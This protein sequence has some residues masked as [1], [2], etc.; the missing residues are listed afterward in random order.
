MPKIAKDLIKK[1]FKEDDDEF[2][3]IDLGEA[4]LKGLFVCG[5]QIKSFLFEKNTGH[6]AKIISEW[7]KQESIS[8]REIKVAVKG[9]QT[10]I[11]YLPFPK[12]PKDKLKDVFGYELAKYIPFSQEDVYFDIDILDENYSQKEMFLVLAVARK[13]FLDKIIQAFKEQKINISEI[14][15]SSIALINLFTKNLTAKNAPAAL[16]DEN[17][18]IVDIGL[19]TT[20]VNLFK[21]DLPCLSRE[22]KVAAKNFLDKVAKIKELSEAEALD[23]VMALNAPKDNVDQGEV[24]EVLEII[25]EV[26]Y[27]LAEEIKNS[28]D[29]FEINFGQRIQNIFI[30]GGLAKVQGLAKVISHSLDINTQVWDVLSS[31]ELK[32]DSDVGEFKEAMAVAL[33]LSL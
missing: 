31:L 20:V 19:N 30:T 16:K 10:L 8:S 23:F 7:L 28:L 22:I 9:Q 32:S 3:V 18:A 13:D 14:N 6:P 25:E 26:S 15:L 4:Y 1:F 11:R 21:K 24:Q 29:Y 2:I 27:E 5:N 12:V 17:S 33:G